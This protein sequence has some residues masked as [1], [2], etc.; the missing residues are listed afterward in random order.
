MNK[1]IYIITL[2]TGFAVGVFYTKSFTKPANPCLELVSRDTLVVDKL[3]VDSV[4]GKAVQTIVVEKELSNV[5]PL[6]PQEVDTNVIIEAYFSKKRYKSTYRDSVFSIKID[7]S[8]LHGKPEI[9]GIKYNLLYPQ[10][11]ITKT[12][13]KPSIHKWFIG[14]NTHF[15]L[16]DNTLIMGPK[17]SIFINNTTL[18]D[19]NYNV[20]DPKLNAGFSVSWKIGKK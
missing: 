8:I 3:I 13:K 16:T 20:M 17:L 11:L 19:F 4:L 12:Y 10:T 15:S 14:V 7:H 6:I 9:E 1:W 18:I 2:V 5:R